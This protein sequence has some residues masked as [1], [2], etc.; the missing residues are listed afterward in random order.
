MPPI[1]TQTQRI[2]ANFIHFYFGPCRRTYFQTQIFR[3]LQ[4][5][6]AAV[7]DGV[8]VVVQYMLFIN[9]LYMYNYT[10]SVSFAFAC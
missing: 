5:T 1:H 4:F 2:Q 3:A 8:D 6:V 9:M 7:V 10:C